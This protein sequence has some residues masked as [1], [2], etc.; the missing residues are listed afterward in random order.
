MPNPTTSLNRTPTFGW[1]VVRCGSKN[2]YQKDTCLQGI[3]LRVQNVRTIPGSIVNIMGDLPGGRYM[4][5]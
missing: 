2:G 1:Y 4:T 3:G 5:T